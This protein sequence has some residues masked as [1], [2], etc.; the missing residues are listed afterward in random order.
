MQDDEIDT[1]D[2]PDLSPEDFAAGIVRD[3]MY[4]PGFEIGDLGTKQE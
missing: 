1:S 3:W 4:A 2:V